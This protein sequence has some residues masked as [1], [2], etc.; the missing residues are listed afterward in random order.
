MGKFIS[1]ADVNGEY[2][3]S[4]EE[5]AKRADLRKETIFTI[6]PLT[7]RDFDDALSIRRLNDDDFDNLELDFSKI[8]NEEIYEI[9]VHIAD[10]SFFV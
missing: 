7:A 5:I 2:Q 4:P 3:I 8:E 10:A 1:Q 9:G 6:D